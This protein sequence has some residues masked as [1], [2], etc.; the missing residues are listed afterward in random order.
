MIDDVDRMDS[1]KDVMEYIMSVAD[2]VAQVHLTA[3]A[4]AATAKARSAYTES[5]LRKEHEQRQEVGAWNMDDLQ[6]QQLMKEQKMKE[7]KERMEKMSP[8]ARAKYEAHMEKEE[9][10]KKLKKRTKMIKV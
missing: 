2:A 6:R 5:L 4:A 1:L 8:E 7:E 10:K 3:K 9:K